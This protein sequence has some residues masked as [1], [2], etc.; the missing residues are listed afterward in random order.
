MLLF[1]TT[2]SACC[3]PLFNS[4]RLC[5][6][7]FGSG[8]VDPGWTGRIMAPSRCDG[9][10]NEVK[11][12]IQVNAHGGSMLLSALYLAVVHTSHTD[13]QNEPYPPA[14]PEQSTE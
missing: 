12:E 3:S 7:L 14:K 5:N 8:S 2:H 6:A 1:P 11:R 13:F 10:I 4:L 9:E